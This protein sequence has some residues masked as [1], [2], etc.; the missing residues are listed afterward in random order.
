MPSIENREAFRQASKERVAEYGAT[1]GLLIGYDENGRLSE[2]A[3]EIVEQ[4]RYLC[5][6]DP[7]AKFEHLMNSLG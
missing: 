1:W 3:T 7:D 5:T 4:L 2:E 6:E